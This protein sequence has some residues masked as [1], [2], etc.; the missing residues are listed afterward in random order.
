MPVQVPADAANF[1]VESIALWL[2][3]DGREQYRYVTLGFG[4]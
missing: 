3:R 1:N 2:N 4:N